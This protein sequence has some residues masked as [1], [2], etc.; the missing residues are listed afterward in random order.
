MR[1]LTKGLEQLSWNF[2]GVLSSDSKDTLISLLS[3][4]SLLLVSSDDSFLLSLL[5]RVIPYFKP[6]ELNQPRIPSEFSVTNGSSSQYII[7]K[8]CQS[9][10]WLR[11][12]K[13]LAHYPITQ[14]S[15]P[16][17]S[18]THYYNITPIRSA[19]S[20]LLFINGCIRSCS[21]SFLVGHQ[22]SSVSYL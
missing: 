11:L 6:I 16:G 5:A 10:C 3:L 9:D 12:H 14:L 1:G 17:P 18:L 21:V 8:L 13:R 19:E 2:E 4:L 15:F 20:S 22:R 7:C